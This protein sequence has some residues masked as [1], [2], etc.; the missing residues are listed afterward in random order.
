[1]ARGLKYYIMFLFFA[2]MKIARATET[3]FEKEGNA[4]CE[5]NNYGNEFYAYI[6]CGYE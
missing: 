5:Q 1:M 2:M 6:Q 4:L 3:K